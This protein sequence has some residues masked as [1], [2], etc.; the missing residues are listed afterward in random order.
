MFE[1]DGYVTTGVVAV[2]AGL[3]NVHSSG[4]EIVPADGDGR[5]LRMRARVGDPRCDPNFLKRRRWFG[6]ALMVFASWCLTGN[7]FPGNTAAHAASSR[8]FARVEPGL[9]QMGADLWPDVI[10]IN[11]RRGGPSPWPNWDEGRFIKSGS[12]RRSRSPNCA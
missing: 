8:T 7:I 5:F 1:D 6:S 11:T 10:D 9:F 2:G 3:R 4:G 12:A